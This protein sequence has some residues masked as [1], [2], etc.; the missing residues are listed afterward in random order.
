MP[1][2]TVR[3][4]ALSTLAVVLF[5]CGFTRAGEVDNI[6]VVTDA[7]PDYTDMDSMVHSITSKWKTPAEKCYAMFIANH[8]ARCQTNPMMLHGLEL[9][10]PIRQFNDYGFTMCST[11]SGINCSIWNYMGLKAKFWDLS[12]HTVAEVEYDGTYHMYDNSLSV[13]Y[14]LCDGKTI[15]PVEAVAAEGACEASGGKKEPGHIAKYHAF[16]RTGNNGFLQGADCPRSLAEETHTFGGHQYRYYYYNWDRGHRYSLNLRPNEVYTRYYRRLD[17]EKK[18]DSDYWVTLFGDDGKPRDPEA[19]NPRYKLRGNGIRTWAPDLKDLA[20]SAWSASNV[21]GGAAVKPNKAGDAGEVIFKVEGANVVT[22][23]KLKAAFLRKSESDECSISVSTTNGLTWKEVWKADKAGDLPVDLKLR[24]EVNGSYEVL[25]KARMLGK[26]AA[27]DAQLKALTFETVTEVNAHAQPKLNLGKN[28]V[29]VGTGEP[30]GSSVFWPDLR[31]DAWKPYA[32]DV[33]DMVS[34]KQHAGY[35]AVMGAGKPNQECYVVFKM[36]A[37]GDVTKIVY[38]GRY[39]ERHGG[40]RQELL[41][42]FDGGKTWTKSWTCNTVEKP[43][44]DEI[45]YETVDKVPAGVRSVLFKYLVFTSQPLVGGDA[46][47][48]L[49]ALRMEI[50]YQPADPGFAP[51]EV[52]YTWKEVQK[53]HS[54]VERSHTEVVTKVPYKYTINVSGDD[55]PVMESLRICQKGA[56]GEVKPGYSDGKDAGGEK[57]VDRWVTYGKNYLEGKPY[58]VNVPSRK[59]WGSGDPEGKRLTDGVVGSAFAGG[60]A[61]GWGLL[62]QDGDKPEINVDMGAAQT[63]GAFR[64][65]LT[66]G[67]PWSDALKWEV[68]DEVEVFTSEDGK[69]YTSRGNFD[70]RLRER[71]VPINHMLPDDKCA[72]GWNF[73][74][75]LDKPVKAQFVRFKLTPK[76]MVVVTEV[77]ALDFIKYEPWDLKIALPDEK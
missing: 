64:I 53:D 44:F 33:K 48:G 22:S 69:D 66:A 26:T 29:Y 31:G 54:Q 77:Q 2:R 9:A 63:L 60:P 76:R 34:N 8:R 55:H 25:V 6:K 20:K 39:Y 57:W 14:T 30:A 41:H 11:I 49:Y 18:P 65:H 67:W 51:L 73:E 40:A 68:K 72:Q 46:P 75:I 17:D 5:V 4:A 58:T 50:N 24:D 1:S 3:T 36:D 47:D 12:C 59:A 13:F 19:C 23:L 71:E 37:P 28:T 42:S 10:D 74:L 70:F 38:G 16:F 7:S 32:V 27:D 15:A 62:W 21:S 35:L 45:H 61:P 52:T 56:A 43:P